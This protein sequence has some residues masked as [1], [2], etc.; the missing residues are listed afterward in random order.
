VLMNNTIKKIKRIIDWCWATLPRRIISCIVI[1]S[2]LLS[3]VWFLFLKPAPVQAAWWD[4]DWLYRK[5]IT[6]D[7]T[8]ID[9]N[10]TNFP[11][12]VK[13]TS[14]QLDF[15]KAQSAGQDIRFTDYLGNSLKYEIEDWSQ[16]SSTA[17]VWV[18]I[19]AISGTVDTNFYM[20]YGNPTV[21]DAQDKTNVWNNGQV[22]V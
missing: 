3:S 11:V 17:D 5:K 15:T 10:L 21:A 8:K 19:P 14:S 1:A 20:Y 13:L 7:Q 12:L 22:G 9:A 4:E 16:A 6:I 18:K 2:I